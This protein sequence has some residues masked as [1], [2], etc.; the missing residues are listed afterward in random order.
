MGDPRLGGADWAYTE[1]PRMLHATIDWKP[2][3]NGYSGYWPATYLDDIVVSRTFPSRA[4]LERLR[5]RRVRFVVLHTAGTGAMTPVAAATI[6]AALPTTAR[7][8]PFGD[9]WLIDLGG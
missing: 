2:R 5:E 7:A 8:G 6:V 1:S 3:L 9:S 4:S